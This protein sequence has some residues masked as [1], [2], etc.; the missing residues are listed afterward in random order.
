MI[1][2]SL[3]IILFRGWKMIVYQIV[4]R[5]SKRLF[6]YDVV[7]FIDEENMVTKVD[8]DCGITVLP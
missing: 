1:L 5:T 7:Q 3:Q 6:F 8:F 4:V 2:Q